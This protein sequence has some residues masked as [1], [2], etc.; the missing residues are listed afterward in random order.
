M[1]QEQ[2][3]LELFSPQLFIKCTQYST[4]YTLFLIATAED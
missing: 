4:I 2:F 3:V 1:H